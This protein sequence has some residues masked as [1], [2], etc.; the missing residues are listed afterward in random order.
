M[1]A[2]TP[3]R[4]ELVIGA[5]AATGALVLQSSSSTDHFD[6]ATWVERWYRAGHKIIVDPRGRPMFMQNMDADEEGAHQLRAEASDPF[7]RTALLGFLNS[8]EP[9]QAGMYSAYAG[10]RW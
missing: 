2:R 8:H 4:R 6:P 5:I 10:R 7:N 9:R 1:I 3:S